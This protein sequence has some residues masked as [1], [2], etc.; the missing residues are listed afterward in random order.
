MPAVDRMRPQ[1]NEKGITLVSDVPDDMPS[2]RA[3]ADRTAQVLTNLLGN[4]LQYTASGGEVRVSLYREYDHLCCSVSDTGTG[5]DPDDIEHIF[6][7]FYRVDKSRSRSSGGSGIG[8]TVAK[9]LVEAQSGSICA[10]SEGIGKGSE[11]SFTLPL[12]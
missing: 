8:L 12:A 11:F 10:T 7:R 5:L 4:A 1:F 6:E 9:Y 3:D 2:V